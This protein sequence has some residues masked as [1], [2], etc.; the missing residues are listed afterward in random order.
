MVCAVAR[1]SGDLPLTCAFAGRRILE[2]YNYS[3]AAFLND[4]YQGD[5]VWYEWLFTQ[6]RVPAGFWRDSANQQ[7]FFDWTMQTKEMT[8]LDGWYKVTGSDIA[9]MG[10]M[11]LFFCIQHKHLPVS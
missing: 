9:K 4:A 1:D 3:V 11:C 10:G 8:S 6:Q 5:F 7:A 2:L